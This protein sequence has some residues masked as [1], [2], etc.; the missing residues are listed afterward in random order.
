MILSSE[1]LCA[2][3]EAI[4]TD[5]DVVLTGVPVYNHVPQDHPLPIIAVRWSIGREFNTKDS[6]GFVGIIIVDMWSNQ[7]GD[8]EVLDVLG[9]VDAA[10]HRAD[11][12]I[13]GGP[14][15]VKITNTGGSVNPVSDGSAHHG[16]LTYDH[17]VTN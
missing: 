12:T 6:H 15:S 14:Q 1:I 16:Q 8:K 4:A 13:A 5:P 9:A 10:L 7:H 3:Y 2:V 17:F 11:L